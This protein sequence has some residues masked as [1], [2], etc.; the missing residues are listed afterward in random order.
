MFIPPV[1]VPCH[2]PR[3]QY[4][5][6][7]EKT[8]TKTN[9]NNTFINPINNSFINSLYDIMCQGKE[10]Y[11]SKYFKYLDYSKYQLSPTKIQEIN[12]SIQKNKITFLI[13]NEQI[14]F[15]QINTNIEH[16]NLYNNGQLDKQIHDNLCYRIYE[17]Y[18][19]LKCDEENKIEYLYNKIKFIDITENSGNIR[20]KLLICLDLLNEKNI[21]TLILHTHHY[22]VQ[23]YI[24]NEIVENKLNYNIIIHINNEKEKYIN[25]MIEKNNKNNINT[26]II[27]EEDLI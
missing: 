12:E 24:Y 15:Q 25:E 8:E 1:I 9:Q 21:D 5:H 14:N 3:P 2:H 4:K 26:I 6:Y 10:L 22:F 23:S 16:L 7:S 18:Q 13:T 20:Q 17:Y 19:N 11:D 27:N